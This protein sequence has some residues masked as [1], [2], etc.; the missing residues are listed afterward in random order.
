[1]VGVE[2][3]AVSTPELSLGWLATFM[4]ASRAWEFNT[5]PAVF[6][7]VTRKKR[8]QALYDEADFL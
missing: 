4:G 7:T 5:N 3:C 6:Y 2:S 1:M 8:F